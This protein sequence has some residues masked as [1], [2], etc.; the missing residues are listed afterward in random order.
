MPPRILFIIVTGSGSF[1]TVEAC[2]LSTGAVSGRGAVG[3]GPAATAGLPSKTK[4]GLSSPIYPYPYMHS[5]MTWR[6]PTC[7]MDPCSLIQPPRPPGLLCMHAAHHH[8]MEP[9]SHTWTNPSPHTWTDVPRASIPLAQVAVKRFRPDVLRDDDCLGL[10]WNEIEI[11]FSL[12][13]R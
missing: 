6:T 3:G 7:S 10:I 4:V 11:M 13:N 2:W 12:D 9:C 1:A 5:P 8:A